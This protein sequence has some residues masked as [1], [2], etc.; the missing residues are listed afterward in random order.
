MAPEE[1]EG[2]R[3]RY[4]SSRH[5]LRLYCRDYGSPLSKKAALLCLAGIARN[6]K[7]FHKPALRLSANR[8]VVTFDYRGR[9]LSDYESNIDRYRPEFHLDDAFQVITALG[10]HEPV[11]LGTSF[12]GLLA[13]GISV[14]SPGSVR[15]LILNDI[16]PEIDLESTEELMK[17]IANS[18]SVANWDQAVE[19]MKL[20]VPDLNLES[21]DRWRIFAEGTFKPGPDGRLYPDWDPKAITVASKSGKTLP[22]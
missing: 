22:D 14:V 2:Y 17:I 9:G 10:L 19:R 11:L 16:G 15:G 8:R 1:T 7:D 5:G 6:S 3:E 18:T 21:E 4:V 20:A 13:M 12:G